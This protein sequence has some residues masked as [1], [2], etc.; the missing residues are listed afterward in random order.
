MLRGTQKLLFFSFQV[1]VKRE[2]S[3]ASTFATHRNVG[4]QTNTRLFFDIFRS[5]FSITM[6]A[7]VGF[8]YFEVAGYGKDFYPYLEVS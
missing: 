1:S 3:S 7:A 6:F 4:F 5:H 8:F 2:H